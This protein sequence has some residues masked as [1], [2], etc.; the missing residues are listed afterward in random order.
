M[1]FQMASRDIGE[2]PNYVCVYV[3]VFMCIHKMWFYILLYTYMRFRSQ[4]L[5]ERATP[6]A[7]P[8]SACLSVELSSVRVR[9]VENENVNV[10]FVL[11]SPQTHSQMAIYVSHST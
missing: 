10:C 5:Y 2:S 7:V 9:R 4:K 6:L 8:R 11:T 1:V 3:C